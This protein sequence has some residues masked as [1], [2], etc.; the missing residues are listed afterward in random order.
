MKAFPGSL[1]DRIKDV[2]GAIGVL[3][4]GMEARIVREDGTEAG[5]NEVGELWLKGENVVS[6]Y[7]DSEMETRATFVEKWMRTGDH[8]RVDENHN[9]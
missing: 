3:L 1:N 4:P 5:F 8:F 2:P 9:F 6:G 7:I